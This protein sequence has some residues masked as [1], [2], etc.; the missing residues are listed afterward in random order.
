[1]F[2]YISN[3]LKDFFTV[4]CHHKYYVILHIYYRVT[5]NIMK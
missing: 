5:N 1:M 2:D 4:I 3:V